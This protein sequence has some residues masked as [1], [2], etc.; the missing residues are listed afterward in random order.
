MR[1]A[2]KELQCW[3]SGCSLQKV[4]VVYQSRTKAEVSSMPTFV[5][6]TL[7]LMIGLQDVEEDEE[8]E[9]SLVNK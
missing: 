7:H 6:V 5:A 3:C 8:E 1:A 4:G 2:G 9:E